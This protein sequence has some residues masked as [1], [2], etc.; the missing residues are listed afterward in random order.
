MYR[1]LYEVSHLGQAKLPS[2]NQILG[3]CRDQNYLGFSY[4][5]F[6]VRLIRLG[7]S[8]Q[9][10]KFLYSNSQ[11]N[12]YHSGMMTITPKS[13]PWMGETKPFNTLQSHFTDFR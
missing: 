4:S 12:Y 6:N 13:Q 10:Q 2:C 7:L 1:S 3:H 5:E 9:K 8:F 11:P